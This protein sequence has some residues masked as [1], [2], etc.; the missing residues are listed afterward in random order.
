MTV[1]AGHLLKLLQGDG[2][3]P[4]VFTLVGGVKNVSSDFSTSS[5]DT[6]TN[7]DVDANG[8]LWQTSSP[9]VNSARVSGT[10]YPKTQAL[11]QQIMDDWRQQ[12]VR[13][14]K[15]EVPNLGEIVMPMFISEFPITGETEGNVEGTIT[16]LQ[17]AS[18]TY[19]AAS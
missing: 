8:V 13:N 18:P 17:T 15:L 7:D 11:F 2:A 5:T 6:T 19:T 4:E 12:V 14:Y 1:P 9:A 10:F 16:L 3:D